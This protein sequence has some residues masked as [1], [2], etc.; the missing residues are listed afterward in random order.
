M[1]NFL[2]FRNGSLEVVGKVRFVH[3]QS[4]RVVKL[5]IIDVDFNVGKNWV[6]NVLYMRDGRNWSLFNRR[7][8]LFCFCLFFVFLF[9]LLWYCEFRNHDP[10]QLSVSKPSTSVSNQ[11]KSSDPFELQTLCNFHRVRYWDRFLVHGT[12]RHCQLLGLSL[13]DFQK[14]PQKVGTENYS[15]WL[16]RNVCRN[17]SLRLTDLFCRF[18]WNDSARTLFPATFRPPAVPFTQLFSQSLSALTLCSCL[19]FLSIT[20]NFW[21]FWHSKFQQV[22][23]YA[24]CRWDGIFTQKWNCSSPK[25]L[26]KCT[27]SP[28]TLSTITSIDWNLYF[29]WSN[30]LVTSFR[31]EMNVGSFSEHPTKTSDTDRYKGFFSPLVSL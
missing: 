29:Y 23:T 9:L 30:R 24:F 14:L 7:F 8:F 22:S 31:L 25:N 11:C 21:N 17:I 6:Q 5:L 3:I 28:S 1:Q 2:V 19:E 10:W 4:N 15:K 20:N 18:C 13:Q 27:E 16:M 26:C 12:T